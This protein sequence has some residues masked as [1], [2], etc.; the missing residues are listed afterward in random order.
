MIRHNEDGT[1]TPLTMPAHRRI[2]QPT[3]RD[4]RTQAG[5]PRDEFMKAFGEA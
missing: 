5:I 1:T 3:P 4:I 2:K